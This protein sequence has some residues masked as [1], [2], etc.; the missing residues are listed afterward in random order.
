MMLDR[1][2]L[3]P[4]ASSPRNTTLKVG[5]AGGAVSEAV[6]SHMASLVV[7]KSYCVTSGK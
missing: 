2:E 4:Q 7:K 3:L 6:G 1:N 5:L